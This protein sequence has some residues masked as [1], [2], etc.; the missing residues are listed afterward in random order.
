MSQD[1]IKPLPERVR[2]WI[3]RDPRSIP[4]LAKEADINY[5]Q[6]QRFTRGERSLNADQLGRLFAVLHVRVSRPPKP[7]IRRI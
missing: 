6:L 3:R 1:H 7:G 5:S 2:I 4:K